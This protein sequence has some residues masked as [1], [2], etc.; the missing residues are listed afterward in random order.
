MTSV[1]THPDRPRL[2]LPDWLWAILCWVVGAGYFLLGVAVATKFFFPHALGPQLAPMVVWGA[3]AALTLQAA[4]ICWATVAPLTVFWVTFALF[5]GGVLLIVDRMLMLSP[6]LPLSLVILVALSRQRKWVFSVALAVAIDLGIYLV[7]G[8]S[9]AGVTIYAI[10]SIILRVIPPY[11]F[12]I[13]TGL[14]YANQRKRAALEAERADALRLASAEIR[15]SAINA[16][17][18]RIAREIHDTLARH[19]GSIVL[20]SKGTLNLQTNDVSVLR[21]ALRTV[22]DEGESALKS[23]RETIKLLRQTDDD[24]RRGHALMPGITL[25]EGLAQ[26]TAAAAAGGQIVCLH[27]DDEVTDVTYSTALACYR[28]VQE[29]LGNA[30][31][32]A[33]DARVTVTVRRGTQGLEIRVSNEESRAPDAN[34]SGPTRPGYGLIGMRERAE[35]LGGTLIS[36]PRAGGGWE[37][38]ALLPLEAQEPVLGKA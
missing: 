22:R 25:R 31:T 15:K 21:D 30:R 5:Q 16:E 24:S 4:V 34:P 35:L 23:T 19:L 12:A 1:P 27:I 29:S 6:A 11:V 13:L 17:R 33:P 36:A 14:L 8:T 37:T 9:A 7:I 2:I 18:T 3:L 32:H 10:I 38:R 20:H 26:L 28:I